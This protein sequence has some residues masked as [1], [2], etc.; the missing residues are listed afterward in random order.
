MELPITLLADHPLQLGNFTSAHLGT[1]KSALTTSSSN[2]ISEEKREPVSDLDTAVAESLK[3][4]DLKWP[5]R[6]ADVLHALEQR[7]SARRRSYV[8]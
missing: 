4:L 1:F 5:I 7:A 8:G 2:P 6:E 3:V